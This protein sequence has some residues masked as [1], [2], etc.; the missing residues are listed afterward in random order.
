MSIFLFKGL[1]A[2]SEKKSVVGKS[3]Q[4]RVEPTPSAEELCVCSKMHKV[5]PCFLQK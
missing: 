2:D 1:Q 5:A 3:W 4:V